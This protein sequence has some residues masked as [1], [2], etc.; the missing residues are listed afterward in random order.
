M[1]FVPVI[2]AKL[3]LYCFTRINQLERR[4]YYNPSTGQNSLKPVSLPGDLLL[5]FNGSKMEYGEL[6]DNYMEHHQIIFYP[7]RIYTGR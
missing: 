7:A 1:N 4:L 2:F 6:V 3:K 5:L